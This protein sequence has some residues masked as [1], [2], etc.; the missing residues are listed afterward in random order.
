MFTR[1]MSFSDNLYLVHISE[2]LLIVKKKIV[3]FVFF[4]P[5]TKNLI[6]K[7]QDIAQNG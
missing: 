1:S 4:I 7:L 6:W 5:Q 2:A 3:D